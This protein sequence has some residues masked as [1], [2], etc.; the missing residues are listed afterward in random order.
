MSLRTIISKI[1]D[2][3]KY[4]TFYLNSKAEAIINESVIDNIF[5]S[6]YITIGSNIQK[7]HGKGSD[8]IVNLVIDHIINI[9][10]YNPLGG[11]SYVKLPK[12]LDHPKKILINI[13][14]F[15]DNECFKWYLVKN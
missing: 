7:F 12:E 5:K 6:I 13:Q 14:N 3:T 11:S 4:S 15:Y 10:K 2:K 8:W 1:D 9:S